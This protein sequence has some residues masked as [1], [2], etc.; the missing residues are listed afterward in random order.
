VTTVAVLGT[1]IMGAPFARH[2][3]R[4]GMTV[5]AW[6]RTREKAEALAEDGVEVA[7]SAAAA[8]SGADVVLTMLGDG[9]A[10]ED[11]MDAGGAI[12]AVDADA[13]WLQTSTV[14]IAATE[15][16]A[17]L[18]AE[19]GVGFVDAPVVGTRGPA[20]QGQVLVLAAGPPDVRDRAAPVFDAI[21][22]ETR[23]L[24]EEPG[25]ASRMKLVFN[26]WLVALVESLAET[27]V[28]ARSV[29]VP[30]GEF[31]D[32][33][34]DSPLGLAY[35]ELKGRAMVAEDFDEVAFPLR[36]AAKD[37]RLVVEAAESAGIDLPLLRVSAEQFT[38]AEEGSHG[39]EDMAAAYWASKRG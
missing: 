20:E 24:G 34:K 1:G 9:P 28:F 15:R 5:R 13:V 26:G 33:I 16:L 11:V 21:G 2:I 37:A 4:A 10:V 6:N 29:G 3:A 23:W 39:E 18:A 12:A 25:A 31:L 22:R 35:A 27:L 14:G 30:P 8:A 36:W 32:A 19:A 38:R 17:A 7:D